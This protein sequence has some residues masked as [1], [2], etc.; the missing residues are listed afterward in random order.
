MNCSYEYIIIGAGASG[1]SLLNKLKNDHNKDVLC[2]EKNTTF[3]N[4]KNF[5]NKMLWHSPYDVCR[6]HE[7]N[8]IK[9]NRN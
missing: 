1:I 7:N 4:L 9:I 6:L 5:M 2:I 8:S 3:S